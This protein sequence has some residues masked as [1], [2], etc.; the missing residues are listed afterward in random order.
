TERE[1]SFTEVTI[2]GN[3]YANA[4]R[5]QDYKLFTQGGVITGFYK[6]AGYTEGANL[7]GTPLSTEASAAFDELSR[8]LESMNTPNNL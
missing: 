6:I 5:N 1:Y 4:M 2:N 3:A 7:L 8:E